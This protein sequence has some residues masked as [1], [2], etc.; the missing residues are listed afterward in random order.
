M[1][2]LFLPG[3]ALAFL[4][5]SLMCPENLDW[6]LSSWGVPKIWSD[7][8]VGYTAGA[9]RVLLLGV[10]RIVFLL[11][12]FGSGSGLWEDCIFWTLFG[13]GSCVYGVV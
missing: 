11:V 9:D 12:T 6:Q 10:G 4:F 1:W 8:N 5:V 2:I 7:R 13:V 3:T